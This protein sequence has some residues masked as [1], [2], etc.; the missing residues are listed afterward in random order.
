M[1]LQAFHAIAA[2]NAVHFPMCKWAED[3]VE[4]L[5]KFPAGRWDDKA[6][7][8][9]LIGRGMDKMF[10]AVVP[11]ETVKPLLIPFTEKWL[12]FNDREAKPKQR[13]F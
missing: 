13:Y 6:D 12:E 9:G 3:V 5:I 2:A 8:C 4:Q 1:K 11:S 7:C 10:N